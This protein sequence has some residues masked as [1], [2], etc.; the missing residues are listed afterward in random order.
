MIKKKRID[1]PTRGSTAVVGDHPKPQFGCARREKSNVPKAEVCKDITTRVSAP[2]H[3]PGYRT[4]EC[5]A[6]DGVIARTGKSVYGRIRDVGERTSID[7]GVGDFQDG[8]ITAAFQVVVNVE[9]YFKV[10]DVD[11]KRRRIEPVIQD[12]IRGG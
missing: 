10:V 1:P 5:C 4:L 2:S 8:A 11:V 12:V 3:S 7:A 6:Y 9:G